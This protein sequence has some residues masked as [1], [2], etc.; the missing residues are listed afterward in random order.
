MIIPRDRFLSQ[1][2]HRLDPHIERVRPGD[3][4]RDNVTRFEER[5]ILAEH[6]ERLSIVGVDEP[7]HLSDC[8][9][10]QHQNQQ[11]LSRV[12]ACQS[13]W[14]RMRHPL[15][16]RSESGSRG[17]Y[18]SPVEII[19][20]TTPI[21]ASSTGT[22]D[23]FRD[24]QEGRNTSRTDV[25]QYQYTI[26]VWWVRFVF[27]RRL[28]QH[29]IVNGLGLGEISIDPPETIESG[30]QKGSKCS[31]RDSNPGPCRERAIRI[32]GKISQLATSHRCR[33]ASIVRR[34]WFQ[35][36]PPT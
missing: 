2:V 14:D 13:G 10:C 32:A 17:T 16:D 33:S 31:V 34:W 5:A 3:E 24:P 23:A 4:P 6:G 20:E 9:R 28:A 22:D 29:Y 26:H 19:S 18:S 30:T 15:N 27:P 1:Y 12:K 35:R 11:P 36:V 8:H 21:A 25:Q 7:N